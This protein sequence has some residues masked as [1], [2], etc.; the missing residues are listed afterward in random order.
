M[1][2]YFDLSDQV[3]EIP[4]TRPNAEPGATRTSNV[5]NWQAAREASSKS[6][7][8]RING[9]I[10]FEA[11]S[12]TTGPAHIVLYPTPPPS[13]QLLLRSVAGR[14]LSTKGQAV[15]LAQLTAIIVT[16]AVSCGNN[17]GLFYHR[18]S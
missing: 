3:K 7:N 1:G 18:S 2:F 14:L 10:T 5:I 17:H 12:V 4:D 15:G 13:R 8:T 9:A 16:A 6:I 11:G